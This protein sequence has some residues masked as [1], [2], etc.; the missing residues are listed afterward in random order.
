[1]RRGPPTKL[2]SRPDAA[3][4]SGDVT[5]ALSH[6][7]LRRARAAGPPVVRLGLK[8][9]RGGADPRTGLLCRGLTAIIL[10]RSEFQTAGFGPPS[11]EGSVVDD[12]ALH[13][14]GDGHDLAGDVAGELVRGER[15]DDPSDVVGLSHLP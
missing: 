4:P 6:G 13:P 2:R 3:G 7:R 5:A 12:A 11:F 1:M 14:A 10:R 8:F 9:R 15:D